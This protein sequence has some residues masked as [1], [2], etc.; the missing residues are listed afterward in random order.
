MIARGS[1]ALMCD[2]G[3]VN[4]KAED[5]VVDEVLGWAIAFVGMYFQFSSGFQVPFPLNWFLWPLDWAEFYLK[6]KIL[7]D[8]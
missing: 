6:A 5:T 2:N 4:I 8:A 3:F 7:Q 1:L